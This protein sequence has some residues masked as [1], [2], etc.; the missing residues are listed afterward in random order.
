MSMTAVQ[1]LGHVIRG[2][3]AIENSLHLLRSLV[4]FDV[5]GVAANA[6]QRALGGHAAE[7]L[8]GICLRRSPD[9]PYANHDG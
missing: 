5:E 1:N 4:Q 6:R 9:S 8:A 7:L 3:W 2:H